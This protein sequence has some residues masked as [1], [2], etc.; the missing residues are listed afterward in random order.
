MLVG[1]GVSVG[2]FI[3]REGIP[4]DLRIGVMIWKARSCDKKNIIVVVVMQ[5]DE[6]TIFEAQIMDWY[7]YVSLNTYA[8][9]WRYVSITAHS[10]ID[11]DWFIP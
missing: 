1:R 10:S 7:A 6:K 9:L 5:T 8:Y 3:T 2:D 11:L 4:G